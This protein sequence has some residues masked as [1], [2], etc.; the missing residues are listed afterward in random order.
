MGD[1]DKSEPAIVL[2]KM[3]SLFP[4]HSHAH[5]ISSQVGLGGIDG[6]N[7]LRPE[8][9]KYSSEPRALLRAHILVVAVVLAF[10]LARAIVLF[11]QL[12]GLQRLHQ[13]NYNSNAPVPHKKEPGKNCHDC[14][15]ESLFAS[16]RDPPDNLVPRASP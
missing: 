10:F 11:L 12:E 6:R 7:G 4:K 2:I 15:R 3:E 1:C 16:L 13:Q 14:P 8:F 9:R 5:E